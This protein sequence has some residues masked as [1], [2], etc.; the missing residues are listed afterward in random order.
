[1]KQKLATKQAKKVVEASSAM[2]PQAGP[3]K[4]NLSPA[5][6]AWLVASRTANQTTALKLFTLLN[7]HA[8]TIKRRE[9]SSKAQGLVSVC[10]SLWRA[11]FLA[12]KGTTRSEVLADARS[13]LGKMLVDNAITYPQDRNARGWTFNYYMNNATNELARLS[14]VWNQI[15]V[16]LNEKLAKAAG[17]TPPQRRWNRTQKA[18]ETAVDALACAL[19]QSS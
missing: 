16:V 5:H 2:E 4:D 15:N 6:L 18:F 13:F 3:K 1:M 17:L 11:A 19:T 7:E 12:D 10:F 14:E 9:F 8:D